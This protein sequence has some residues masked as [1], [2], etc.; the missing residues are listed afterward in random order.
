LEPR[1]FRTKAGKDIT[2]RLFSE[3]A[4]EGLVSFYNQFEP[5]EV[6]QGLPPRL[7]SRRI[8]WMKTLVEGSLAVLA[9]DRERVIGHTAAIPIPSSLVAELLVFVHQ[10]FRNQ[11]IGTELI[12]LVT[13]AAADMGFKTLWLTVSTANAIAI[14]VYRKCGFQSISGI[15]CE[16][17]MVLELGPVKGC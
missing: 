11:G 5:K 16:R 8:Q 15:E 2:I 4:F 9:M 6:F 7:A 12:R 1:P 3:E 10:D 17:E 14:H 13:D